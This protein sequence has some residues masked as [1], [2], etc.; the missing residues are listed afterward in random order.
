MGDQELFDKSNMKLIL[1]SKSYASRS[2]GALTKAKLAS[3]K[4]TSKGNKVQAMDK[5][6]SNQMKSHKEIN[7]K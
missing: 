3:P 7:Q 4:V 6:R 1:N 5:P 2:K